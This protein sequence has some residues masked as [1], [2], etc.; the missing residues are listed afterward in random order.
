MS[1]D[2]S[3]DLMKKTLES[4]KRRIL[5]I[6]NSQQVQFAESNA[7]A[8]MLEIEQVSNESFDKK[9]FAGIC[10]VCHE[11]CDENSGTHGFFSQ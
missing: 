10:V 2:S 6:M 1:S 11:S 7:N 9:M 3:S 5:D 4:R 8:A